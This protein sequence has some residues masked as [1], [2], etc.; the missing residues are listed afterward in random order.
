M[1]FDGATYPDQVFELLSKYA[2]QTSKVRQTMQEASRCKYQKSI[3]GMPYGR[4]HGVHPPSE[5]TDI[6]FTSQIERL[7]SLIQVCVLNLMHH[8]Q[9]QESGATPLELPELLLFALPSVLTLQKL[10]VLPALTERSH[11][12]AGSFSR[13]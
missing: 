4:N 8:K 13:M 2:T 11:Q 10:F 1:K 6:V 9:L 12:F 3:F 7:L 5:I